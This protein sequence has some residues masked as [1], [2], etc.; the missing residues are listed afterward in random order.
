MCPVSNSRRGEDGAS[1]IIALVFVLL[2]SLILLA[3]V[4]LSGTNIVNTTNL[5]NERALEYSA[6][7]GVQAALQSVRYVT[8]SQTSAFCANSP[9]LQPP[10]PIS[11][12]VVCQFAKLTYARVL[13]FEACDVTV[14]SSNCANNVNKAD[15]LTATVLISDVASGCTSGGSPGCYNPPSTSGTSVT[16]E[17][18]IVN[19]ANG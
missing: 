17:S 16:V 12:T 8:A 5:Q 7:G 19:R 9:A 14:S 2:I 11:S 1:L 6:E 3:I 15:V 13:T 4:T 10:T 18:W